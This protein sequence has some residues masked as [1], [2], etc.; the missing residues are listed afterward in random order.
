MTSLI[1][2]KKNKLR[3]E[4]V[5]GTDVSA[6]SST[7]PTAQWL[8]MP[9]YPLSVTLSIVHY[10]YALQTVARFAG[11]C[12]HFDHMVGRHDTSSEVFILN[13]GWWMIRVQSGGISSSNDSPN[14]VCDHTF[15]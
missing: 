15:I 1:I 3:F 12:I 7:S 9:G 14:Q 4:A 11:I 13:L 10:G 6:S 2:N 8:G 5:S